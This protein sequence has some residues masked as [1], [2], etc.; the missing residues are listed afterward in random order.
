MVTKVTA[1]SS[2]IIPEKGAQLCWAHLPRLQAYISD[3]F[4]GKAKEET[5]ESDTAG[6]TITIETMCTILGI[7]QNVWDK[8]V[9]SADKANQPIQDVT[10]CLLVRLYFNN[11]GLAWDY[12]SP[13]RIH[14]ILGGPLKYTGRMFGREDGSAHRWV[15]GG[16][17]GRPSATVSRLMLHFRDLYNVHGEN[18]RGTWEDMVKT[19]YAFHGIDE[20]FGKSIEKAH[21]EAA[22]RHSVVLAAL[23]SDD[24]ETKEK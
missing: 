9:R 23:A 21:S 16:S 20:P 12:V 10:L 11:P 2:T 24:D 18:I 1:R 8:N 17:S 13:L 6:P 3:Y 15:S 14:Q 19:E 5:N 22:Q 4:K 7:Q